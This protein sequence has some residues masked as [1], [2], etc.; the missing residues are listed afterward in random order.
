MGFLAEPPFEELFRIEAANS[1]T[2]PGTEAETTLVVRPRL[3]SAIQRARVLCRARMMLSKRLHDE[4]S[5]WWRTG[6]VPLPEYTQARVQWWDHKPKL[7]QEL[8][9]MSRSKD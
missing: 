4:F 9:I 6:K 5:I 3:S 1:E 2:M 7:P 8:Q